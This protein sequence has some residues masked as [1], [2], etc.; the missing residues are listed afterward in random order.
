MTFRPSETYGFEGVYSSPA[1]CRQ[2]QNSLN[3]HFRKLLQPTPTSSRALSNPYFFCPFN[4]PSIVCLSLGV[5]F[6]AAFSNIF[7][8]HAISS[9]ANGC[10]ML[11]LSPDRFEFRISSP[12]A[13]TNAKNGSPPL[14][15]PNLSSH[16]VPPAFSKC[17][18][19]SDSFTTNCATTKYRSKIGLIS[20]CSI[21]LSSLLHHPHHDALKSTK[22]VFASFAALA[23]AIPITSSAD[24]AAEPT[25]EETTRIPKPK[26]ILRMRPF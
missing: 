9:G 21:N 18:F 26:I 5:I 24:G 15:P 25:N 23:F 12:L 2:A 14:L 8:N 7:I 13:S 22:I 1:P 19:F 4:H 16:T 20:S 6:G 3:C 10:P 17:L 11:P